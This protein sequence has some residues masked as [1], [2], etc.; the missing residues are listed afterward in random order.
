MG[1][2]D[3]GVQNLG[4]NVLQVWVDGSRTA[5][6]G[7]NTSTRIA[8]LQQ[9]QGR[10]FAIDA[11][12]NQLLELDSKTGATLKSYPLPAA[13]GADA[14][15][16][17]AGGTV[18]YV[19]GN[20]AALYELHPN[21]GGTVD[22]MPLSGLSPNGLAGLAYLNGEVVLLD[23]TA[24]EL[25]FSDP[26]RDLEIRR[27]TSAT[28]LA[29]GLVGGGSRGTLFA[30][31]A[32]SE[33]VELNPVDGSVVATIASPG[34][35]LVGLALVDGVLLA[36]DNAGVVYRI[37]P[38]SGAVLGTLAVPTGLAALGAD[39]GGGMAAAT[40]G[41]YQPFI[42]TILD[43]EATTS[44]TEGVGPY[45]GRYV[46]VQPLS[47]FDGT[48]VRGSWRLEIQDTSTR[49]VGVLN[50]WRLLINETQDT[51]PD[52]SHVGFV[53]DNTDT[54]ANPVND[55]DL[56]RF[57]VLQGGTISVAVAPTPGLDVVIRLFDSAGNPLSSANLAGAG[58]AEN[59]THVAA[60]AGVY[61]VGIS[62]TG[63]AAYD[64]VTGSGATGGTSSGSYKMDIRFSEY[65][66]IDDDNS[67][68]ETAT[69]IGV[70]GAGGQIV[71]A[72]VRS[73]PYLP[74]LPGGIDEPGHR[75]I[76]PETHLNAAGGSDYVPN[77]L[78]L[79]F[80]D[81]VSD[82]RR[83]E[84]LAAQGLDVVKSFDFISALVVKTPA[85]TDVLA[86]TAQLNALAEVRYADPDYLQTGELLSD[87]PQL[88]Q[89]WH[90]DNQGQTGGTIDA[91]IDLPEA[92]DT[93]TGSAQTVI[94]VIDS[95]VDYN[96]PDLIANMW[97]NPGEI[98]GDGID[99]DGN[100]YID[101]IY[102]IDTIN[103]D[104]DPLDDHGHGTH[105][106]GTTSAVGNN[107][108]GVTGVN[109][110]AKIMALKFLGSNN[111]GPISGAI[112]ALN[113]MVT[114]KTIYDIN[115]VVSN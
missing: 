16:A 85:G 61:F 34:G 58:A 115:I 3:A 46:P 23:A 53:G 104:A 100:G 9:P 21:T 25:I 31:N 109:W 113:Y 72:E 52:V 74:I 2:K 36:S 75:D 93:F 63:N 4:E 22:V 103:G 30:I 64:I 44:I 47:A 17:Y 13:A 39:G 60:D 86:K 108:L 56:Y 37:D 11:T 73:G 112:E 102:G 29:G 50:S 41:N 27:V 67:S 20:G 49:N 38:T 7:A 51:P 76:P 66:S 79:R 96:H 12:N 107:G 10:L 89:Q 95:G 35:N 43:D 24:G 40:G 105:T 106:A 28:V 80:E 87:D 59:L 1:I 26:Y 78:I 111:S 14:G 45:T 77:Q 57:N 94:A 81:G 32:A 99:N 114:M 8:H 54:S 70:L 62:S 83:T 42:N 84:I 71:R 48:N 33:I 15:L 82:Q 69:P 6:V 91:D 18:Y 5:L 101:D 98:A 97:I 110:N 68:F 55:V 92:W 90:Y 88:P 65:V 19:P